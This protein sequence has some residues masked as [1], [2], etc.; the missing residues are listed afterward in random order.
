V[1]LGVGAAL[2]DRQLVDGDVEVDG[3]DGTIAAVGVAGGVGDLVA[4]PGFVDLQVNGIGEV[5]LARADGDGYRAV[6]DALLAAGVTAYQPTFTTAPAEATI[7]ALARLADLGDD[8]TAAPRVL[9]AHLEGPFLSP[10]RLGAHPAEHRRDPDVT[11]LHMLLSHGPVRQVT[12]A[13][14]LPGALDLVDLLLAAG[15]T[16]S[17]GHTDA[18]AAEAAT[19]FDRG[20]TTVTHLFN[21]MHP[22]SHRDPGI[23]YAALTRA[24][25]VVQVIADG[26]HLAPE[27]V[28][29]VWRAA[30]GGLA[31]VS[32]ST[33]GDAD[34]EDGAVRIADGTLAGGAAL[35]DQAVRNLVAWGV[36]L[37]DALCA[38]SAAPAAIARRADLGRLAPGAPADVVVLD[39]GLRVHRT[40]VAGVERFAA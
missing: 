28:V 23:A 1:R 37:T 7:A 6:G 40:L 18:T 27:T 10:E 20:A 2:V 36:P 12:L 25:V 29:V 9:G 11:L 22:P 8:V 35:L 13:P 30:A 3:R 17:C 33:A 26:V 4:A 5:S 19:A 15:V 39:A 34:T 38:A 21:A 31:V 24:D 14:E 16:I 32:D